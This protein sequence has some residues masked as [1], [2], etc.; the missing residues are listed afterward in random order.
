MKVC[1]K[2]GEPKD[3]SEFYK[4]KSYKDGLLSW[5]KQ[6][7]SN[8]RKEIYQNNK[9]KFKKLSREYCQN[10]KEKVKQS[11]KKYYWDNKDLRNQHHKKWYEKNKE[12]ISRRDK[13]KYYKRIDEKHNYSGP[14][15][16]TLQEF[17]ERIKNSR[18][19]YCNT[20]RDLGLDR[21]D[22]T[23]G[24]SISN[25]LPACNRCNMTRSNRFT[26]DEMKLIG[27]VLQEID[28]N[29]QSQELIQN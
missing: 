5:C 11:Q 21:I 1:N 26:V 12:R 3:I 17:E 2:C 29:K 9:E 16:F 7:V 18:C 15:D 6:C 4:H 13:Y 24:H 28:K 25:T 8:Y 10:N 20:D 22:N 27:I 23:K 14:L 19:I